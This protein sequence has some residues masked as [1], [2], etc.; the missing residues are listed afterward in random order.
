MKADY[1]WSEFHALYCNDNYLVA[2]T[3]GKPDSVAGLAN[4]DRPPGGGGGGSGGYDKECVVRT[5]SD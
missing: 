5:A 3:K 4:I 1:K 2:W